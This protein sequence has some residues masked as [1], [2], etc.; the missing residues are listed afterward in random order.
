MS[1]GQLRLR[2]VF[3]QTGDAAMHQIAH[4]L[5]VDA[6]NAAYLVVSEL[7]DVVE[8]DDLFLPR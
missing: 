4:T 8:V 6:H 3:A 1:D 7:L 5:V 2:G